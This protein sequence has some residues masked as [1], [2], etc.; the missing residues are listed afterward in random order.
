MAHISD[1]RII[2]AYSRMQMGTGAFGAGL[3]GMNM[4][5]AAWFGDGAAEGWFYPVSASLTVR[6]VVQS[7]RYRKIDPSRNGRDS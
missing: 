4:P 1:S 2:M 7:N 3:F 6:C 5:H